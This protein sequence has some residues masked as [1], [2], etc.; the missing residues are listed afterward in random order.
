MRNLQKLEV[1][2]MVSDQF[3]IIVSSER[4]RSYND[5]RESKDKKKRTIRLV[6]RRK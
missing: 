2:N 6:N 5:I 1:D 4:E 3:L